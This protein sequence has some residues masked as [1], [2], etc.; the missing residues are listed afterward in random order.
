[1]RC[2]IRKKC[3]PM[4][5]WWFISSSSSLAFLSWMKNSNLFIKIYFHYQKKCT[6]LMIFTQSVS[7]LATVFIMLMID[8]FNSCWMRIKTTDEKRMKKK[9][10]QWRWMGWRGEAA[11]R[12]RKIPPR[13]IFNQLLVFM[14]FVIS[15][16]VY[17]FIDEKSLS[18]CVC[19]YLNHQIKIFADKE[20]NNFIDEEEEKIVGKWWRKREKLRRRKMFL[21]C[22]IN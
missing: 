2:Q 1:M 19:L 4:L 15:S 17:S 16:L 10:N 3:R 21:C 5:L 20:K 13:P 7:Q 12:E 18:W 6:S 9:S 22:E 14:P 11:K 8:V